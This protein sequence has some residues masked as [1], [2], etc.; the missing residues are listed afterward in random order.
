MPGSCAPIMPGSP[1]A[2]SSSAAAADMSVKG[3]AAK[4]AKRPGCF[5]QIAESPSLT[6]RHSGPDTSSG[7]DS[8]QQNEPRSDSTL[9]STP[10]RSIRARWK[11]T[12]S[13]ASASGASPIRPDCSTSTPSGLRAMRGSLVRARRAS[14]TS[15]GRQ[16]ACM[17][18]MA[19]MA[20]SFNG[21]GASLTPRRLARKARQLS[22]SIDGASRRHK[23]WRSDQT[24]NFA[25]LL[26]PKA[27]PN[28]WLAGKFDR[29]PGCPV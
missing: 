14:A 19:V 27:L 24:V 12:S 4:A 23:L 3:S 1:S 10:W 5:W 9:V 13:K 25:G 21:P 20:V 22:R 7:W 29:R 2:R 28:L 26:R 11:S 6:F 8:I 16:W 15:A 18:I 17:S